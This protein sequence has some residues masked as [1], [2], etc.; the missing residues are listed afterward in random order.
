MNSTQYQIH[1]IQQL[2]NGALYECFYI[3]CSF[4]LLSL[5][6]HIKHLHK[7][8][9][10][11]VPLANVSVDQELL[12]QVLQDQITK[13]QEQL[14]MDINT[15]SVKKVAVTYTQKAENYTIR[16]LKAYASQQHIKRYC[17]M[18]KAELVKAIDFTL[19]NK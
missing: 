9:I 1:I 3:F 13:A 19:V 18:T 2:L 12:R 11:A 8:S 7:H 15:Y 6:N 16:Q 10:K 5:L 4:V 17:N 14:E